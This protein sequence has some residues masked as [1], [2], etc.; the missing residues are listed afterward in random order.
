[1]SKTTVYLRG[2]FNQ[3]GM[4]I[5]RKCCGK[6]SYFSW[7]MHSNLLEIRCVSPHCLTGFVRNAEK[8]E[9]A[10]KKQNKSQVMARAS[11]LILFV[12][13]AY[14]HLWSHVQE[15]VAAPAHSAST[16]ALTHQSEVHPIQVANSDPCEFCQAVR[17][18]SPLPTTLLISPHPLGRELHSSL[19]CAVASSPVLDQDSPRA[20][21]QV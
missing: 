16:I 17:V 18:S 21:P 2:R 20:P 4:N 5:E 6:W 11:L 15:L 7:F 10:M 19:Q 12:F 3:T 13:V 8:L 14:A 1:M 9:H